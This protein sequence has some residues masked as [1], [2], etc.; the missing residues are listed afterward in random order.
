MGYGAGG[1]VYALSRAVLNYARK[2]HSVV[3]AQV[4]LPALPVAPVLAE[5]SVF[6][7]AGQ[8]FR[9]GIAFWP[10]QGIGAGWQDKRA[11]PGPAML[12]GHR[13]RTP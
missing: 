4:L 13:E 6:Y 11:D 7:P 3:A 8:G 2:A 5:A 10:L 9:R 1:C 12:P